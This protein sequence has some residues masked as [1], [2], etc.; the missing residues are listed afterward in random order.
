MNVKVP[1]KCLN[2]QKIRNPHTKE[3]LLVGCGKCAACQIQKSSM[4]A[5]KCQLESMSHRCCRFVTL[6]YSQ[7]YVPLLSRIINLGA[8]LNPERKMMFYDVDYPDELICEENMYLH[9]FDLLVDKTNVREECIPYLRK[10]DL[11]KFLKRFRKNLTKYTDEK[12]RYYAVGEYGPLHFRP[13]YH[14]LVWFSDRQTEAHFDEVLHKSWQFGR[15]D[16]QVPTG[17]C[18]QYVAGYLNGFG[19]LPCIY[20]K[21]KTKPFAIHSHH[22]GEAILKCSKEEVYAMPVDDFIQR[23]LPFNGSHTEFSLWRSLT[24]AYYPRCPKFAVRNTQECYVSYR[25]YAAVREWTAEVSPWKQAKIVVDFIIANYGNLM[26]P[27][28]EYFKDT[29]TI[30]PF[31][32]LTQYERI[33]RQVYM[34]LRTSE[35]FLRFVCDGIDNPFHQLNQVQ[36]IEHFYEQV[37]AMNLTDQLKSQVDWFRYDA[38]DMDDM[39]YFYNNKFFD[40]EK[41]MQSRIFL[42]YQEKTLQKAENSVKH[43]KLNDMNKIFNY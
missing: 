41:Y 38:M 12:I 30:N 5:L 27:V 24:S 32:G 9:Q 39:V 19:N 34:E 43:K 8:D 31:L 26:L 28:L 35:H 22:L 42:E 13:H 14:L 11:Q 29:Y 2:P 17:Q 16:S 36:M 23:S 15:I 20:Q 37:D 25:T 7:E 33:V 10:S 4:R 1:V 40:K 21:P 3:S 18:A 6:T